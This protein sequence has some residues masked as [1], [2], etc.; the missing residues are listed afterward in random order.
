MSAIALTLAFARPVAADT[1]NGAKVFSANAACHLGGRNVVA[2]A[3]TLK[4][5]ALEKYNMNSLEAIVS[6]VHN[7]IF[8]MPAFKGRLKDNHRTYAAAIL[9]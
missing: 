5:D 4:K 2:A 3:K 6:Q 7:G 1:V 8:A 9:D